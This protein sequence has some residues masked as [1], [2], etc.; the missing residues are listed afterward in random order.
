MVWLLSLYASNKLWVRDCLVNK[1]SSSFSGFG[2][3][4]VTSTSSVTGLGRYLTSRAMSLPK[5]STI[6]SSSRIIPT[7]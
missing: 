2:G 1:A 5:A 7:I 3:G 4:S 6:S